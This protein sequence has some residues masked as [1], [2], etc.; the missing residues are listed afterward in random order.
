MLK[1]FHKFVSKYFNHQQSLISIGQT[2]LN[3][4][5]NRDSVKS[6]LNASLAIVLNFIH[7]RTID[8][9]SKLLISQQNVLRLQTK[10]ETIFSWFSLNLERWL[11]NKTFL[12]FREQSNY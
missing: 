4:N 3:S 7:N 6:D 10:S 5:A 8:S 9:I 1:Y 12:L 11:L 2:W